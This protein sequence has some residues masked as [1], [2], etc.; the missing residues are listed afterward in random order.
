MVARVYDRR[1]LLYI[2]AADLPDKH[3]CHMGFTQRCVKEDEVH[4][5]LSKD[6]GR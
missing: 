3:P 6:F 4:S 1:T 2:A 5:G